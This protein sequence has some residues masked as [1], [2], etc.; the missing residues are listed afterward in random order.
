MTQSI[1]ARL[2]R[3]IFGCYFLVTLIVTA[4]Q[5][6]AEYKHTRSRVESEMQDPRLE[7]DG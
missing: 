1:A 6:L 5:L 4:V 7:R 2:L 3:I